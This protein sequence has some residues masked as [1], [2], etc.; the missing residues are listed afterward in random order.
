[1][2]TQ[3]KIKLKSITLSGFKSF[4]NAEHKIQFGDVSVLI[5]AN[6]AGKSNLVSFFK[7]VGFMMTKALQQYIGEQGLASS[8]LNYGP[9]KTPRLTAKLEFENEEFYDA[10]EFYLSHAAQDSLIFTEEIISYHDKKFPK[11]KQVV[12]PPGLKESGLKMDNPELSIKPIKMIHALLCNCRVYQFHDTSTSAKIRNGGYINQGDYLYSDGGNLAAFL[13]GLK[14]NKNNR[15]YYDKIVRHIKQV[16]PQF[17]GFN[18]NPTARNDNYIMLDWYENNHNEYK[19][20]PHQISDGTLRFMALAALLL[21]PPKNLPA[22]I[23]LDEPELGL[24]PS[25]IVELAG[26]VKTASQH[27]QV[28]MATQNPSLLD[29]FKPEQITVIERNPVSQSS[30]FKSFSEEGLHSWLQDFT[31]SEIWDK[32]ILGGKP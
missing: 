3:N 22:V 5:G 26:M 11:G 23:I 24:H 25:A 16:F 20:G 30:Q 19:F 13:Y 1:M 9:K 31:L 15:T 27:T 21:Q 14:E 8:L 18:L 29:E 2:E 12:L 28:I 7:M 10:Y 6:G 32:N 17:E 4:D